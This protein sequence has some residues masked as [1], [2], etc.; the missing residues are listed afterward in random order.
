MARH[1]IYSQKHYQNM[2]GESTTYPT[3][4]ALSAAKKSM[5]YIV[6]NAENIIEYGFK[7]LES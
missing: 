1:C 7:G 6:A 2:K 3:R 5:K 4:M